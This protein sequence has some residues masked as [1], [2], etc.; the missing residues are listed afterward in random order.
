[1][2]SHPGTHLIV[3]QPGFALGPL[4]AVFDAMAGLDHARQFL[5]RCLGR[6]IGQII[7]VF[8][9]T[10]GFTGARYHQQFFFSS[11]LSSLRSCQHARL[12]TS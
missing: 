9:H 6:C 5:Q 11:F 3:G 4:K 2:P 12:T 8:H 1:M 7:I 10:V